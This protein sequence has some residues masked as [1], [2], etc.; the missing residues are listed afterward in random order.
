MQANSVFALCAGTDLR[1]RKVGHSGLSKQCRERY[2]SGQFVNYYPPVAIRS[3]THSTNPGMTETAGGGIRSF[4]PRNAYGNVSAATRGLAGRVI[5]SRNSLIGT[6]PMPVSVCD[7]LCLRQ[8]AS[9][10][11]N[12]F[13]NTA[14]L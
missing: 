7:K 3:F 10:R 12:G 8:A 4:S 1:C 14:E 13:L 5:P 9:S 11:A 2:P 6:R